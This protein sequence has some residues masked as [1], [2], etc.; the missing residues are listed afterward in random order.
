MRTLPNR[1]CESPRRIPLA[2]L[3]QSRPRDYTRDYSHTFQNY[4]PVIYAVDKCPTEGRTPK[5]LCILLPRC[6]DYLKKILYVY[7]C[8]ICCIFLAQFVKFLFIVT[9]IFCHHYVIT[10]TW[11]TDIHVHIHRHEYRHINLYETVWAC[12]SR[13]PG[14]RR[15][16]VDLRASLCLHSVGSRRGARHRD[17]GHDRNTRFISLG[18]RD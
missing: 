6:V 7:N 18:N 10:W 17:A 2:Y 16:L 1:S 5:I 9:Y 15:G 11:H 4:Q 12:A 3:L 8:F 14:R 13:S